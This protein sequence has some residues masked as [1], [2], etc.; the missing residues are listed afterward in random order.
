MKFKYIYIDGPR[1]RM[2]NIELISNKNKSK[3]LVVDMNTT[4][5]FIKKKYGFE[6]NIELIFKGHILEDSAC[7]KDYN[8]FDDAQVFVVFLNTFKGVNNMG[9][10]PD[11]I[12]SLISILNAYNQNN[13]ALAAE[14]S[15]DNQRYENEMTQLEAMGFVD[16]PMNLRLLILYNGN[17]EDTISALVAT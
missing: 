3:T 7:L 12:T 15:F 17:I 9:G 16:R 6:E 11:L 8:I 5:E 2:F 10:E 13:P 14:L 4:V 1:N